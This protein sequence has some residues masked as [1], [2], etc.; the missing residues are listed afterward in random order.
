MF[1]LFVNVDYWLFRVASAGWM[2]YCNL[3]DV[4]FVM[5]CFDDL[6]GCVWLCWFVFA[7]F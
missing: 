4:S 2:L 6:T 5:M 3:F 1:V 7:G